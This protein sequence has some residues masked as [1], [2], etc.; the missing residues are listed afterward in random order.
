[1]LRFTHAIVT[2]LIGA[3]LLHLVIILALP[4][5][6]ERD[7]FSRVLALGPAASFHR[8]AKGAEAGP[9]SPR[10]PFMQVA[11]CAFSLKDG[12]VAA[13]A[14]GSPEFWSFAAFDKAGNEVFSINDR[15]TEGKGLDAVIATPSQAAQLRKADPGI[16]EERILVEFRGTEGYLVLRSAVAHASMEQEALAFLD[17]A[18]CNVYSPQ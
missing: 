7:A 17:G 4:R 18:R 3:A 12:P 11:A 6:S 16:T 10:D 5:F 13:V 15:S 2:G 1:M 8:L 9:L 14:G